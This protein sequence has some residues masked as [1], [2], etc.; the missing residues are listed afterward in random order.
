MRRA[1]ASLSGHIRSF[2][3]CERGNIIAIFAAAV[4]PLTLAAGLGIDAAKAYSVKVRL[5]AALDAAA[6]AVGSSNPSQFTNTQLQ[7]RLNNYFYANFPAN[8]AIGTP[9]PPTMTPDPN[10]SNLL[11][12]TAQA[13][14]DT[15]FMRMVGINTLTVKVANQITRGITTVELAL[16]L[17]N[18]GSMMCGDGGM[19]NCSSGTAHINALKT[20]AQQVVDTLF[21]SSADT[22]KLKIAIVPYVTAV[23]IGPAASSTGILNTLVPNV[24]GVY[25]DYKGNKILDPT[26]ANIVYDPTQTSLATNAWKGCVIEPTALNEDTNG[27]GPDINDPALWPNLTFTAY[28]WKTGGS[29]SYGNNNNTWYISSKTPPAK[30]QYKEIDGDWLTAT[31]NSY[32]PNLSCP[33]PIVRLTNNQATLDAA[34]QNM[35]S[36]AN[37][38][39]AITVGMIWGWRVL[40]DKGPFADGQPA[41]TPGLKK[42]VVLETDGDQEVLGSPDYTGYGYIADGKLGATTPGALP[43]STPAPNTA[44]YNLGQRL[45]KL[46]TNMKAAGIVIYTIGLGEGSDPTTY[47]GGILSGCAGNGGQFYPAP[48]AASLATVFQAIANDLATLY[49]S[50]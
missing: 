23:N 26:G 47:S 30:I 4:I 17:D 19:S 29:S 21:K 34:T 35:T 24:S 6:L 50:K 39:T 41:A 20:D 27:S 10:N 13:N 1:L 40:S 28:N 22:S 16:V 33:T 36:W 37:S 9:Q 14:V 25:K 32:G 18:T 48:T 2:L 7:Q 49:L 45:K 11:N 15:V 42:V 46:C 8:S 3:A 43:P 44:N 5:G 12:F 31:N 38:G